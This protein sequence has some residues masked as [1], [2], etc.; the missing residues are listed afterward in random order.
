MKATTK[1][2]A[3]SLAFAVVSV[4]ADRDG[5]DDGHRIDVTRSP[6]VLAGEMNDR[7]GAG[8]PDSE[9]CVSNCVE[10]AVLGDRFVVL[11][12]DVDGIPFRRCHDRR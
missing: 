3:V 11:A 4:Y 12:R 6:A 9:S 1:A 8:L 5:T 10:L 2:I 7:Y